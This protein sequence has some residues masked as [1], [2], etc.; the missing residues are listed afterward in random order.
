MT[1]LLALGCTPENEFVERPFESIAVVTGDFDAIEDSFN[2]LDVAHTIYEGYITTSAH[3]SSVDPENMSLKS[4]HLFTG[5]NADGDLELLVHDALFVNSGARGF[6]EVKYKGSLDP[7]DQFVNDAEVMDA[8]VEWT[9]RGKTVLVSDWAY[10][11]VETGWPDY[12]DFHGDDLVLD[13]AEVGASGRVTANVESVDLVE[14]LGTDTITLE[15]NYTN[16]AVIESVS[17][18]VEVLLRG[19]IEYRI[20]AEEGW[21][22][23][24]QVPLLV[25]FDHGTGHVVFS[26]FHW[27]AQNAG[28]ADAMLVEVVP[29]LDPGNADDT[30]PTEE[31]TDDDGSE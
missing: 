15:M 12:I 30:P 14:S 29:G 27:H 19:D 3:D 5:T 11:L 18:N 8:I 16:W 20:S 7:D 6:A 1:L 23:K 31:T 24:E 4:E 10:D 2:R 13:D 26:A 9:G 28:V 25:Q 21:G 17:D 22:T